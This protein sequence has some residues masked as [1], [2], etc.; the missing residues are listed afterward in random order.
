MEHGQDGWKPERDDPGSVCLNK[1]KCRAG[2]KE[3]A[4]AEVCSP[5][6]EPGTSWN[7]VKPREDFVCPLIQNTSWEKLF[8][9]WAETQSLMTQDV[10]IGRAH[11]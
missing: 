2:E 10:K 1:R 6:D 9:T 11:V 7:P 5:L 8:Q 4:Q 3:G